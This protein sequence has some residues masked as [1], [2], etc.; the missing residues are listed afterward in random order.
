MAR[1]SYLRTGTGLV[2][3]ALL[4]GV[5]PTVIGMIDSFNHSA[6]DGTLDNQ[7]LAESI[8]SGL[9][10]SMIAIPMALL[11]IALVIVGFVIHPKNLKKAAE[12]VDKPGSGV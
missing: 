12:S 11:G 6:S 8:A 4:I 2:I 7:E 5:A 9:R 1:S 3:F 10:W